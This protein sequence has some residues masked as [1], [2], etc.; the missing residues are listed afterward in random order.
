[1]ETLGTGTFGR[2]RLVK[3]NADE[4]HYALKMLKK[5]DILRLKQVDHIQSEVKILSMIQNPFIVN[6]VG[7][8]Q[9]PVALY[10]VIE[11]VQGGELYSHL[12][13]EVRFSDEK[14]RFYTMEI[15]LAFSYLHNLKIIYRDLK[16]EVSVPMSSQNTQLP[17]FLPA[18]I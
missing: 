13:R 17:L 12:R 6:M 4:T 5:S 9:D 18:P 11:Y 10:M 1:M 15:V 14:S 3:C 2:V 16:P 8:F 7:H